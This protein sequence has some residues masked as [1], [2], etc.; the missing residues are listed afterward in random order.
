M[1]VGGAHQAAPSEVR[2]VKTAI[3]DVTVRRG[4]GTSTE[5][6]GIIP[7]GGVVPHTSEHN[8]QG[9]VYIDCTNQENNYW[10][11]VNWNGASGFVAAGCVIAQ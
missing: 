2:S 5:A 3:D 9:E 10:V 11:P 6:L 4:P 7:K 8:V 1:T